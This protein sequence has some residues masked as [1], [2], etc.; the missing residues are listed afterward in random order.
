[1]MMTLMIMMI[2][3]DVKM[4]ERFAAEASS[5]V[6]RELISLDYN[7]WLNYRNKLKHLFDVYF[8]Y[9]RLWRN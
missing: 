3:D 7:R 5:F 6:S 8:S 4:M 2:D 9:F 1:M